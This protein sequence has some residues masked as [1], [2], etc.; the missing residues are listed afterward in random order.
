MKSKGV[1]SSLSKLA[2]SNALVQNAN[3]E[4]VNIPTKM[5]NS[6]LSEA[7][8]TNIV[9]TNLLRILFHE[10]KEPSSFVVIVDDVPKEVNT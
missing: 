2:L 5:L 1:G 8:E 3:E 9:P 7:T 10:G 4:I 6:L